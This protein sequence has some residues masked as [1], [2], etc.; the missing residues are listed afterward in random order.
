MSEG[1]TVIRFNSSGRS[2]SPVESL[3]S[4]AWPQRAELT[5]MTLAAVLGAMEPGVRHKLRAPSMPSSVEREW[6]QFP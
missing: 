3:A 2:L 6:R 5:V 4:P 1:H